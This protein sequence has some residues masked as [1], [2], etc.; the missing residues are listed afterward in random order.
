MAVARVIP[1]ARIL[2]L[3]ENTTYTAAYDLAKD[4]A[5]ELPSSGVVLSAEEVEQVRWFLSA[6]PSYILGE[7]MLY[8]KP[9]D[10]MRRAA[11][12]LL[13]GADEEGSPRDR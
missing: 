8:D 3:V 6:P 4:I 9:Y 1:V 13:D 11:L 2:A 12:A 7:D 5:A 10:N